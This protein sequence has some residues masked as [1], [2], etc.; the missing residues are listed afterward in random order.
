M[1]PWQ[2]PGL[3]RGFRIGDSAFFWR[4]PE[5]CRTI[6]YN[7]LNAVGGLRIGLATTISP[8]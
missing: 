2:Y 8:L 6:A 3:E 4:D 5:H 7:E 1:I